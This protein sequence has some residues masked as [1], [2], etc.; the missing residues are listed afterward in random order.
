MIFQAD[1]WSS[2]CS[3]A[4]KEYNIVSS[5]TRVQYLASLTGLRIC[6]AA[7]CD[8]GHWCASDLVLLW[9]W[10]R[11]AAAALIQSLA[12]ESPYATGMALK[13]KKSGEPPKFLESWFN[14]QTV[15]QSKKNKTSFVNMKQPDLRGIHIL[16]NSDI[17]IFESCSYSSNITTVW[18]NDFQPWFGYIPKVLKSRINSNSSKF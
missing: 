14:K 6:I 7:S 5:S 16:S 3:S 13:R 12:Q 8:I 2:Y 4:G 18:H 10:C 17:T 9:L 11:P 15:K 1:F